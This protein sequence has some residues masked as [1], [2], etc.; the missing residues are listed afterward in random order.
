MK[1]LKFY[2]ENFFE[3]CLSNALSSGPLKF[4]TLTKLPIASLR[5]EG[6]I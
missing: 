6:V 3:I 5:I 1:Y 2:A 4:T